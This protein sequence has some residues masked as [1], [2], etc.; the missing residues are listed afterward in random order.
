MLIIDGA[1]G[2][3]GGQILRSSAALSVVTGQAFRIERIREHRDKPGLRPQHLCGILAVAEVGGATIEGA[4]VGSR[5]LTFVPG[6]VRP[7]PYRFDIGTAGSTLLVIQALLPALLVAAGRFDLEVIGGTHNTKAPTYDF[8]ARVLAPILVGLG[9]SIEHAM[10]RPGFYPSGGG[11]IR[12]T[13]EGLGGRGRL[14]PLD[15]CARGDVHTRRVRAR[16]SGLP[17]T[18][19]ERQI[20]SAC[21][22][23]GWDPA[24]H[25]VIE[26]THGPG[27]GTACAVELGAAHVTELFAAIGERG[28]PAEQV[29]L[30]AADEAAAWLAAGV[31]VGEHL[32]D[33]LLVPLALG[34]GGRFRTVRPTPH[35]TTQIDLLRQFLGI[36]VRAAEQ[37]GGV[38]EIEIPGAA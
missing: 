12:V 19:A 5:E 23:L 11:K 30:A 24:A 31:P 35:T 16:V 26:E 3:G 37:A 21:A 27:R 28:M 1:H 17:R 36:E 32:A 15:L 33:Q 22:R 7:G 4:A 2:E 20:A 6:A 8:F 9:A 34:R 38:W 25:G 18:I 14:A 10:D 13:A 29:G